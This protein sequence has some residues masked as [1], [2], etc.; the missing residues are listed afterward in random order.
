MGGDVALDN[1]RGR[2][3]ETIGDVRVRHSP[4]FGADFSPEEI[5]SMIDEI[6]ALAVAAAFAR[7]DTLIEGLAELRLKESDRLAGIAAGL[8]ACGVEASVSRDALRIVGGKPDGGEVET[9]G[10]HRLA[11][12]FAILGLAS[13]RPVTV[14]GAAMIATSF[15]GFAG[16]MR[17]LGARIDELE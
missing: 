17:S 14:D 10:D 11:M 12:A 8:N 9:H 13:E 3:G 15:P 16:T 7:G 5:P 4:L 1:V 6:P 2:N